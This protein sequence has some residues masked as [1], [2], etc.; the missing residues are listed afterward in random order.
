M[1]TPAQRIPLNATSGT[2]GISDTASHQVFPAKTVTA[3]SQAL[4]TVLP[5]ASSR[6]LKNYLTDL[7]LGNTAAVATVV[8]ILDGANIIWSTN[9]AAS[10]GPL[11]FN[12]TTP[13]VGSPNTAMN[14][15][16]VTGSA[17]IVWGAQGYAAST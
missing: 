7:T 6:A 11:S 15:Q 9:V 16:A 8:S 14:I 3:A 4:P 17:G 12:F 10:S 1:A 5:N 13:L 2:T